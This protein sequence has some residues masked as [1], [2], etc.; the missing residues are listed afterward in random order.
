[1]IS[2]KA[3]Y[4]IRALVALSRAEPETTVQIAEISR[5]EKIPRKFLE[6]ILLDLKRRGLVASQRGA[7]GGY[8]LLKPAKDITF[9]EV[10]RIVDGPIAPLPCLS[11]TAY[12]RCADCPSEA[13]CDIRHALAEFAKAQRDVLD[14]T[15][16]ASA[17]APRRRRSRAQTSGRSS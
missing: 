9:T 11:Q 17:A 5:A 1:M 4:A 6:Q 16:I 8:A 7:R 12:R 2:K 10:L 15:T 13:D 3:K 14:A